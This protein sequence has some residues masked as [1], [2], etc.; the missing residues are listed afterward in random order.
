MVG[1]VCYKGFGKTLLNLWVEF[2]KESEEEDI[3]F[4]SKYTVTI[5]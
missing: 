1:T 4:E 5:Q 3:D 2:C